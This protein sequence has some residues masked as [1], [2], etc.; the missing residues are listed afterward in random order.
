M[1]DECQDSGGIFV[2]SIM[3]M[4]SMVY[5]RILKR[6][7]GMG[8]KPGFGTKNGG[9]FY[10]PIEILKTLFIKYAKESYGERYREMGEQ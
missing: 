1:E 6:Q 7:L 8:D 5:R 2:K 9:R 10:A 4:V 3:V